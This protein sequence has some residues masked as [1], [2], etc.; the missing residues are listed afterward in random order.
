[1]VFENSRNAHERAGF[2]F[3]EPTPET[4]MRFEVSNDDTECIICFLRLSLRAH[5]C[6][7]G[8]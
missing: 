3:R 2:A 6:L 7:C 8:R 4:V 5:A 1:M